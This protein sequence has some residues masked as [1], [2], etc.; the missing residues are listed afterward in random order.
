VQLGD[1]VCVI[2]L[3]LL[4]QLTVQLARLSGCRVIGVDVLHDRLAL[5]K[6]FGADL[7]Y[8]AQEQ[9]VQKEI[10]FLTQHYG[11][12]VTLITAASSSHAIVQ[13][14]M[15]IT[16]RKG[17]VV[18]VGDVGLNLERSPWYQKEIDFLISCSYGPGRYD[19]SYEQQGNDYPYAYVRWTENRNMQTVAE[20]LEQGKLNV[21]PL[22]QEFSIENAQHGYEKVQKKETLAAVLSYLPKPQSSNTADKKI[23]FKPAT[24]DKTR[25]G[26]VGAGGFA[27]FKL[28]PMVSKLSDVQIN[29][30]VDADIST[31]INVSR[32]YGAAKALVNDHELFDEDMVDVVVIA[33]PHK[34]HCDQSLRSL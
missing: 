24:Q 23:N 31:A 21:E 2:G 7:V 33:S 10:E 14:A 1:T 3:G 29:A 15:N 25:V 12:D 22:L 18:V 5:A 20:L 32:T 27:K 11:V 8:H 34:F 9:N 26:F 4:G 16:R 13:Q 28:I 6:K 30:V 17:K 19:A